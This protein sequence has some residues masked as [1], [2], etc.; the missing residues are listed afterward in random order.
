MK[1][2]ATILVC[3]FFLACG[4]IEKQAKKEPKLSL[5]SVKSLLQGH[6][7][8]QND[9][10]NFRIRKDS[11]YELCDTFLLRYSFKIRYPD[12]SDKLNDN[13]ALYVLDAISN[14][15]CLPKDCVDE[16]GNPLPIIKSQLYMEI[17]SI[18]KNFIKVAGGGSYSRLVK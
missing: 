4:N 17:D 3:F 11:L 13:K 1:S 2:L 12:S 18:N 8:C 9:S 16:N 14:S 10:S 15:L 6:W 5:D 7:T